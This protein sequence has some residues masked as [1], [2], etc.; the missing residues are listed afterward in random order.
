MWIFLNDA[1]LS[2]VQKDCAAGE[3]LVRARR[4]GDLEK[5]F[6]KA[7]VTRTPGADYLFRAVVNTS[8]VKRALADEVDRITYS[9]FKD[10]VADRR[11]HDAYLRVWS[12]MSLLQPV[13]PY[14]ERWGDLPFD[15]EPKP[16]P[17]KKGKRR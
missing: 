12:Q 2:I 1:F 6:P 5:I 17:A 7:K 14:G 11:L 4:S 3:L 10:S 16:R 8:D 9:N 15:H 13:A